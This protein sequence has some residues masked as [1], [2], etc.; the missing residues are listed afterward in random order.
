MHVLTAVPACRVPLLS[1]QCIAVPGRYS[2]P[3]AFLPAGLAGLD[4]H[5][6]T[7]LN[8]ALSAILRPPSLISIP[9]FRKAD[10]AR[11]LSSRSA[12]GSSASLSSL[13]LGA[14]AGAGASGSAPSH[15][16]AHIQPLRSRD[17]VPSTSAISTH[18]DAFTGDG[19]GAGGD[20][21][22]AL[23]ALEAA[24]AASDSPER[25]QAQPARLSWWLAQ[26]LLWAATVALAEVAVLG[27][28]HLLGSNGPIELAARAIARLLPWSCVRKEVRAARPAARLPAPP[29]EPTCARG[30][31]MPRAPTQ[32]REGSQK[33]RALLF[34]R[35]RRARLP[36]LA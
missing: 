16:H 6:H 21:R 1:A 5:E 18:S 2:D 23:R 34:A 14:A 26:A 31:G 12:N 32:Q 35:S 22:E 24:V 3:L 30:L 13:A 8:R 33:K 25:L 17:R 20:A 11:L 27:G 29:W 10:S 15:A 28:C 7:L 4:A 9:S 36:P 19:E